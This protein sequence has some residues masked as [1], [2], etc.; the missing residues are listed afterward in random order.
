MARKVTVEDGQ[1]KW[2]YWKIRDLGVVVA[3]TVCQTNAVNFAGQLG[4]EVFKT[5]C[6]REL[7]TEGFVPERPKSIW[8]RELESEYDS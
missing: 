8:L 5:P 1:G 7:H 4:Q 3:D 2:A 6:E